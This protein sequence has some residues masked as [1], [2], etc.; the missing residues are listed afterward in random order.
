MDEHQ[1]AA[2]AGWIEIGN[3]AADIELGF[4]ENAPVGTAQGKNQKS[5]QG[6]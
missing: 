5:D 4:L 2:D 1:I 6:N 3:R